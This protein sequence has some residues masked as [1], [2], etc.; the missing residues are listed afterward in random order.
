MTNADLLEYVIWITGFAIAG[1]FFAIY[2][3]WQRKQYTKMAEGNVLVDMWQTNG[4][5][6]ELICPFDGNEVFVHPDA[7]KIL[8]GRLDK[9]EG[10]IPRYFAD[11]DSISLTVWPHK[12]G[13]MKTLTSIQIPKVAFFEGCPEPISQRRKWQV[14][15]L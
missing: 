10:S 1:L 15:R 8:K 12:T 9:I 2:V 7:Q 6:P 5:C 4:T 11:K 13:I 14:S 3:I